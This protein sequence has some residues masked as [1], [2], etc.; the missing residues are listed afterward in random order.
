MYR[1]SIICA[2]TVRFYRT[3][4]PAVLTCVVEADAEITHLGPELY[5][6]CCPLDLESNQD[7]GR[8]G[9]RVLSVYIF[10]DNTGCG[11]PVETASARVSQGFVPPGITTI[12]VEGGAGLPSTGRYGA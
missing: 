8:V 6:R 11:C 12:K 1:A 7:A 3:I 2:R 9:P 10:F 4:A 5:E